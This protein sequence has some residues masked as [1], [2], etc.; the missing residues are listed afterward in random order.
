MSDFAP[1]IDQSGIDALAGTIGALGLEGVAT[2]EWSDVTRAQADKLVKANKTADVTTTRAEIRSGVSSKDATEQAS[3]T[4]G[5]CAPLISMVPFG[6]ER[7][8]SEEVQRAIDVDVFAVSNQFG[9]MV[10]LIGNE[11]REQIRRRNQQAHEEG[12]RPPFPLI[13]VM[14]D[15]LRAVVHASDEM[16]PWLSRAEVHVLCRQIEADDHSTPGNEKFHS[17]MYMCHT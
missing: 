11:Q 3:K 1:G 7:E 10:F 4:L 9:K 2:V 14:L 15:R 8:F 16:V 6:C 17:D 5:F 12:M 13:Q